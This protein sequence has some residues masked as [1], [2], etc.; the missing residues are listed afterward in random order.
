MAQTTILDL[1]LE[2]HEHLLAIC[3]ARDIEALG[4]TCSAMRFAVRNL[5]LW[6]RLFERDFGHLYSMR[7]DHAQWPA[8]GVLRDPWVDTTCRG[9]AVEAP[10]VRLPPV[11]ESWVPEPFMHMQSAGKDARWLYMFHATKRHEAD[12]DSAPVCEQGDCYA[13]TFNYIEPLW[14]EEGHHDGFAWSMGTNEFQIECRNALKHGL[15]SHVTINRELGTTC[16]T[17][18]DPCNPKLSFSIRRPWQ[19]GPVRTGRLEIASAGRIITTI[20]RVRNEYDDGSVTTTNYDAWG[21]GEAVTCYPNGDCVCYLVENGAV[22]VIREFVCSPRCP[23]REFA[24]R[25][26]RPREWSR[27]TVR[28]RLDDFREHWFWPKS[29]CS[30]ALA[31]CDYVRRGLVGWHPG[32]RKAALAHVGDT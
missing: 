5:Y 26:I 29:D 7:T 25:S 27:P 10:Y 3:M 20:R 23:D 1:P 13:V 30:D 9:W 12:A 4:A 22:S 17:M 16:W 24:G 2:V 21:I 32:L 14:L 11:G 28:L 15:T 18:G 19:R 6:R 8:D 31:F